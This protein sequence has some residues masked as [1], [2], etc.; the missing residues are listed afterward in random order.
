MGADVVNV[1]YGRCIYI[2]K[3]RNSIFG[4]TSVYFEKVSQFFIIYCIYYI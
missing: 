1:T 2:E 3:V 4:I